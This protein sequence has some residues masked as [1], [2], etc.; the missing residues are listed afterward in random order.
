MSL[1]PY[2]HPWYLCNAH[3]ETIWPSLFRRVEQPNYRRERISTTDDDFLDLDW[4]QSGRKHLTILSH[5]LEGDSRRNYVVGMANALAAN[6]W[7]VLAWNFRGCGGEM[8]R[9]PR[10]TH[11]GAT[12]DLD[13]VVRHALKTYDY[14]TI[15]L[16]GFS[17]GGNLSLVYLG[18]DSDRVP[19]EVKAAVCFSV[20]C[21]LADAS[22]C[23]AEAGNAIYMRR[24]LRL[25]G[26]KIRLQSEKFP[27]QFPCADY[28]K[29]KTFDDF[30][31]RY[32]APLHGFRDAQD[33]WDQCSSNRY[34]DAIRLPVW[35]VNARNDSFLPSSCY[36]DFDNH[37]NPS[38]TLIT[39]EHGGHCG[40]ST[41]GAGRPYWSEDLAV[42]LLSSL[43][44]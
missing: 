40:F 4:L 31:G 37:G 41:V 3:F 36:P 29:L 16:V 21:H 33:Y 30:D 2:E 13:T 20:P 44:S 39:P 22:S 24:F 35:I 7:D 5:G 38:V 43:V 26:K 11:N 27:D 42:N 15:S 32:T 1:P 34:L 18:R 19:E 8:N 28:H 14:K 17:M 9:Q 10:F 6:G 12:D 25:M 23:L